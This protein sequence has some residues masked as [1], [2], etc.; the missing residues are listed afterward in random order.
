MSGAQLWG[1][2][3]VGRKYSSPDLRPRPACS[4]APALLCSA[5]L[6]RLIVPATSPNL[7]PS[8]LPA[9]P[10]RSPNLRYSRH[11]SAVA[12]EYRSECAGARPPPLSPHPILSH[13]NL[14]F[15][16][17]SPRSLGRRFPF[18]LALRARSNH[19]LVGASAA[20]V[21]FVHRSRARAQSYG[22]LRQVTVPRPGGDG[23]AV[24]I[25]YDNN[26]TE[27][28]TRIFEMVEDRDSFSIANPRS[29][30]RVTCVPPF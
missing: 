12:T 15:I 29:R 4:A 30:A 26:I 8:S 7:Q 20:R 10:L 16:W 23:A 24:A 28:S 13:F 17:P 2:R 5:P 27:K 11:G 6:A 14:K 22:D 19:K 9:T 3:K 21:K 18:H 25:E 1:G